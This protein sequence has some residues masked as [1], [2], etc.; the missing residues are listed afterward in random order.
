MKNIEGMRLIIFLL[1][2]S[3]S[4]AQNN[5]TDFF[6]KLLQS[7]EMQSSSITVCVFDI[8]GDSI[9]YEKNKSSALSPASTIKLFTT[10]LALDVLGPDYRAKTKFLS[11]GTIVNGV[12]N[13]DLIIQAGGD[14]SLGSKY[15]GS[16]KNQTI[17]ISEWI[18]QLLKLGINKINGNLIVDGSA[19]GY[20]GVPDGWLWSDLGNYYG[21]GASGIIFQDNI[22]LYNFRTFKPGQ[23]SILLST[24]PETN[25]FYFRNEITSGNHS[26]DRSLIYGGPFSNDRFGTGSLPANRT[27]YVVKG[28]LPDPE[29]TLG[30]ILMDSLLKR[31]V[32]INDVLT[33]QDLIKEKRKINY[34]KSTSLFEFEGEKLIDIVNLTNEKSINLFAEQLL[35]LTSFEKTGNGSYKAY[36]EFLNDYYKSKIQGFGGHLVDGS[37]LSRTN[38]LSAWDFCQ[39]LIRQT[40]SPYYEIFKKSLPVAGKTGTLRNMCKTGSARS[41]VFAKSGTMNRV[42][43]YAGYVTTKSGKQLCFSITM[44]NHEYSNSQISDKMEAFFNLMAEL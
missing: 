20:H 37:G 19:F 39:L 18:N 40:K 24:S 36:E 44:N 31:G 4:V 23:P 17:F 27:I 33:G 28:S 7:N 30:N 34:L 22:L 13:G 14:P 35:A 26:S 16:D 2:T 42:K 21:A 15:F 8:T 29:W 11:N 32:S 5:L 41:R 43:S 12:L 38:A 10:A 3:A 6:G 9:I 1:L 25:N